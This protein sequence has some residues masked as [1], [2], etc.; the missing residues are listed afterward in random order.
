MANAR[1]TDPITSH[2]TADINKAERESMMRKMVKACG[3]YPGKTA[4]ELARIAGLDRHDGMKR[5][6]DARKRGYV[7][8]SG[9]AICG[10]S[11]NRAT[12][13][14]RTGEKLLGEE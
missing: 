4:R 8:K 11:G 2:L 7:A 1:R 9:I 13:W 12:T 5:M 14:I 6:N 10:D 3:Q